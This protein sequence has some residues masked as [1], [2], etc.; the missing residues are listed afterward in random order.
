MSEGRRVLL[1]APQT[2]KVLASQQTEASRSEVTNGHS[3]RV[4][5]PF[6]VVPSQEHSSAGAAPDPSTVVY[7]L[8]KGASMH[9][10]LNNDDRSFVE[11]G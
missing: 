2:V 4:N 7:Y 11:W 9:L 5:Y 6:N 8:P 10:D 1:V 3:D